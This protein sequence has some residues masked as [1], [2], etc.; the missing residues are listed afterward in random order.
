MQPKL[1]GIA[2]AAS[3]SM[4]ACAGP[5]A[6]APKAVVQYSI[7]E[8]AQP[9]P[10]VLRFQ[11]WP[12]NAGQ[13]L[14]SVQ[15]TVTGVVNPD[16]S[17][18]PKTGRRF[19]H[20]LINQPPPPCEGTCRSEKPF[21]VKVLSLAGI[22]SPTRPPPPTTANDGDPSTFVWLMPLAAM[23]SVFGCKSQYFPSVAVQLDGKAAELEY[24][25]TADCESVKV[26][27]TSRSKNRGG[28]A[29]SE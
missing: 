17:P 5:D 15:F 4:M 13:G 28:G 12:V 21:K 27:G 11:I 8:R 14:H 9:L 2:I 23:N 29:L 24:R 1:V 20:N 26:V 3:V 25:K 10:P 19:S 22:S 6:A 18:D 7:I 16:C